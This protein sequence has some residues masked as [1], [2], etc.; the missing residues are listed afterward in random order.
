[1]S[2]G[3][4]NAIT[5]AV[6]AAVL[7]FLAAPVLADEGSGEDDSPILGAS[8]SANADISA[9]SRGSGDDSADDSD[10][11]AEDNSET[12]DS[13]SESDS[14]RGNSISDDR[15]GERARAGVGAGVGIAIKERYENARE[16][17]L[18]ARGKAKERLD[19]FNSIKARFR[20]AA[21]VDKLRIRS[22]LKTSAQHVLLNQVNAIINHLDAIEDKQVAPDNYVEV[23]AFFEAKQQLLL[24]ANISQEVLISTSA[25][26][27]E[28]WRT[29][30]LGVEKDV[31]EKLSARFDA[32]IANAEKFS[33]RVAAQI[34]ELKVDGKDTSLLER[35]LAKLN[36]D[37][38]LFKDVSAKVE[39][40]LNASADANSEI[41]IREA[42]QLL[43]RMHKQ[44][45]VDFR[46]MK[47]LFN[48]TRELNAS[49]EL[50]ARIT[51]ELNE[52]IAES[53]TTVRGDV[54]E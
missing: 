12:D 2:K 39:A 36:A 4:E 14:D 26:I 22:A 43:A 25:E 48:A 29:H 50:S 44:L 40:D 47:S 41:T 23:R 13:G 19:E 32:I 28:Y 15:G 54:N 5:F 21:S 24:D 8:V 1:M 52:A 18:D 6:L 27:R 31:G 11:S 49:A 35:G 38:A 30:R 9:G 37:I 34:A 16:K 33:A 20:L 53:E 3:Y 42:H 10:D 45:Q 17:Y 46:L 51:A 7:I